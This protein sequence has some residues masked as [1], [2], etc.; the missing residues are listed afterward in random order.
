M[1]RKTVL[2]AITG[3]LAALGILVALV[4][5]S[6]GNVKSV[7]RIAQ[8][9]DLYSKDDIDDAFNAVESEFASGFK[10]CS[11]DELRYDDEVESTFLDEILEHGQKGKGD[12]IVVLSEFTTDWRA[13]DEGFSP[14]D[15]YEGWQWILT[16]PSQD[17]PW[18]IVDWG[19]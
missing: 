3:A 17:A 7:E 14:N 11:L 13:A 5:P 4:G 6:G 15:R 16:R 19:Y 12:L 2:I 10:G 8:A 18:K 9:T 1:N